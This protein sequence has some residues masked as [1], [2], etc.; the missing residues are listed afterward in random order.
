MTFPGQLP[1]TCSVTTSTTLLTD[2]FCYV[3]YDFSTNKIEAFIYRLNLKSFKP[4]FYYCVPF[5]GDIYILE[6]RRKKC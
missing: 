5:G 1:L 3:Q 2:D 4:L 6:V